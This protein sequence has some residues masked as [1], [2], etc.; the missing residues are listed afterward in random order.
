QET[1]AIDTIYNA[2]S[3]I[4]AGNTY[5]ESYNLN[6]DL[7]FKRLTHSTGGQRNIIDW[8]TNL[9]ILLKSSATVLPLY[10]DAF[11]QF[12][13]ISITDFSFVPYSPTINQVN[14]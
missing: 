5:K 2:L 7:L 14:S 9:L 11:N 12:Y 1:S 6:P 13:Q 8:N 3:F 4:F 10:D